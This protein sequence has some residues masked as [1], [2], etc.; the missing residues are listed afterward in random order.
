MMFSR[1]KDRIKSAFQKLKQFFYYLRKNKFYLIGLGVFFIVVLILI[2]FLPSRQNRFFQAE[3]FD[4]NY[5]Q[6]DKCYLH[7][8]ERVQTSDKYDEKNVIVD[9]GAKIVLDGVHNFKSLE[10]DA[11]TIEHTAPGINNRAYENT[12]YF[13]SKWTGYLELPERMPGFYSGEPNEVSVC[14]YII[15]LRTDDGSEI[16]IEKVGNPTENRTV[17]D[18]QND[19]QS[20]LRIDGGCRRQ[21]SD[22]PVGE[23]LTPGLYKLEIHHLQG[24]GGS[25]LQIGFGWHYY[26][27]YAGSYIL[28]SWDPR[29]Q[30]PSNIKFWVDEAKTRSGMNSE[31][32]DHY[33]PEEHGNTFESRFNGLTPKLSKRVQLGGSW[34]SWWCEHFRCGDTG[35]FDFLVTGLRLKIDGDL[36][37]K[38]G[39]KIDV[40]E[41]GYSARTR[42]HE[43]IERGV[44]GYGPGGGPSQVIHDT[45]ASGGSYGGLGRFIKSNDAGLAGYRTYGSLTTPAADLTPSLYHDF[46]RPNGSRNPP[47]YQEY[48]IPLGS[49][50]GSASK[51][52]L[53][54]HHFLPGGSGGGLVY[55]D[56]GRVFIEMGGIFTYGGDGFEKHESAG[57]GSGGT[58][59]IWARSFENNS[60]TDY[61]LKGLPLVQERPFRSNG[62]V[63]IWGVEAQPGTICL[64][65]GFDM[66]NPKCDYIYQDYNWRDADGN[67]VDYTAIPRYGSS[68][69]ASGGLWGG[70][71]GRIA[72]HAPL[73]PGP[74]P[75]QLE[76]KGDVH[77]QRGI[78]IQGSA[79][80]VVTAG[81]EDLQLVKILGDLATIAPYTINEQTAASWVKAT[82]QY[83]P[84]N[85]DRLINER[86]KSYGQLVAAGYNLN[87]DNT[88][89]GGVWHKRGWLIYNG[90]PFHGRGTIIVDGMLII[91]QDLSPSGSGDMIGFIVKGGIV[92]ITQNVK[93]LSRVAIFA[94]NGDITIQANPDPTNISGPLVAK[95]IVIQR[96]NVTISYDPRV[97]RAYDPINNIVYLALPGFSQIIPPTWREEV[98]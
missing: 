49:A 28:R 73:G 92:R 76:I 88:P 71:G 75:Q 1:Y 56:A 9:N 84:K 34:L 27:Q 62:T 89:E 78:T 79:T 37:L 6:E 90:K 55:I 45:W 72:I 70:G 4:E 57:G 17:S 63:P 24:T 26:Y 53:F 41:K 14:A 3:R 13:A 58:I 2:G 95:S 64:D 68:I 35:P 60:T 30:V 29:W 43:Y 12:E 31:F 74:E 46:Y 67:Y 69:I 86:A 77:A 5:C 44:P 52:G 93:N 47:P 85:L 25:Y 81:T 10:I 16:K 11:A 42:E 97:A 20:Y 98:P 33:Y 51:T 96:N 32:F 59:E 80:G 87:P 18:W 39:G 61:D 15:Q 82:T 66:S 22:P 36:I 94:P 91:N 54:S 8:D 50:G 23:F 40:S 38:N 48:R 65:S 21:G 83:T 7:I 19:H